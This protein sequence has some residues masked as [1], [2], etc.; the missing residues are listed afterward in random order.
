MKAWTRPLNLF[1]A[2]LV[3]SIFLMASSPAPA[4]EPAREFLAALRSRKYFDEALE[5]LDRIAKN[6]AA[7]IELKET[8]L[9]EKGVTL[10]TPGEPDLIPAA[11]QAAGMR[12]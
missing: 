9:Y 5:Y 4:V 7:P 12:S 1:L 8:L 11:I 3:P 2:L 10:V 6:P